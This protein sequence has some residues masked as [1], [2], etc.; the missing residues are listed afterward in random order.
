MLPLASRYRSLLLGVT[1]VVGL[2]GWSMWDGQVALA[3]IKNPTNG[4]Q[5]IDGRLNPRV[6]CVMVDPYQ[7]AL[8]L[9][10]FGYEN[11][12]GGTLNIV[13]NSTV[14]IDGFPADPAGQPTVFLPG[15]HEG[16]F[17][18]RYASTSMV[19]WFRAG[20]EATTFGNSPICGEGP[21]GPAGQDGA[22]GPQ[23]IQGFEGL[24][25]VPGQPGANGKDGA[26]FTFRGEWNGTILYALDDVVTHKGSAWIYIVQPNGGNS[27]DSGGT[28]K[29][30]KDPTKDPTKTKVPKDPTK[31]PTKPPKG[32]KDVTPEP[33]TD[34]TAWA[35]LAR[36]GKRG[37]D[38]LPGATGPAGSVGPAGPAGANGTDGIPGLAGADGTGFT[39][40]GPWDSNGTYATNDIVTFDGSAYLKFPLDKGGNKKS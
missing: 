4:S 5:P 12:T 33:G 10:S 28:T 3:Q 39:F 20:Q 31:D 18:V 13:G 7:P 30:P 27:T 17:W 6:D 2:T 26:S 29:T 19:T 36:K 21:Q 35:L 15:L 11:L 24:P 40:R 38:G 16:T 25:G 32:S 23:G 37:D 9:V 1:V 8:Q 22:Q 34:P 14:V